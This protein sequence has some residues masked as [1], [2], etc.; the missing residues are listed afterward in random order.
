MKILKELVKLVFILSISLSLF[1][2][3]KKKEEKEDEPQKIEINKQTKVM[4]AASREHIESIDPDTYTFIFSGTDEFINGLKVGN[5]LVDGVSDK[6]PYG[7]LRKITVITDNKGSKQCQ[8]ELVTLPEAVPSGSIYFNT[9]NLKISDIKSM[10]LA[11]GVKLNT[12]KDPNFTVFDFTFEKV[13]VDPDNPDRKVTISGETALELDFF[14]NF[15]WAWDIEEC[16]TVGDPSNGLCID[17]K[18]FETGVDINQSGSIEI[19]SEVGADFEESIDIATFIFDPW[20]FSVGPVPVVFLPKIKVILNA[21]GEIVA[22]F[23]ASVSEELT[24]KLGV[25]YENGSFGGI[26]EWE[27]NKDFVAPQLEVNA[28]AEAHIGPQASLLLYGVAGPFV[29]LTACDKFEGS[30]N[31]GTGN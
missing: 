11:E 22:V 15:D 21:N 9:G 24:G 5:I 20:V 25:K 17:V 31:I 23:S 18:L 10:T 2:S 8:T 14:F 26:N 12:N 27:F 19:A 3:C 4:P 28:V 13:I 16:P 30:L 6:A 29:N 7:Y 1:N